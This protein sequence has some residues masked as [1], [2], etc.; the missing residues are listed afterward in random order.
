MED[1]SPGGEG[2]RGPSLQNANLPERDIMGHRE[3]DRW[4]VPQDPSLCTGQ[5][6][7]RLRTDQEFTVGG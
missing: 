4:V 3:H 6:I 1:Q 7:L 2:H 5:I